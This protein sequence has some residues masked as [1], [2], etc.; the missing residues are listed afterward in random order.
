MQ[1]DS[2]ANHQTH[3]QNSHKESLRQ[4]QAFR[5]WPRPSR[6]RLRSREPFRLLAQRL[7]H[8][9]AA[10]QQQQHGYRVE[11]QLDDDCGD[12]RFSRRL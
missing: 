9:D 6:R 5:L 1:Q 4:H 11:Q 8:R 3:S 10:R 2:S 12:G 7:H